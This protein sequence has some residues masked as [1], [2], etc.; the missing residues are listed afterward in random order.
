MKKGFSRNNS[1]M[2]L[3]FE[4]GTL[5][6]VE[7]HGAGDK[8][9]VRHSLRAPLSQN[10][11]TGNSELVGAEIRKHMESA[12]IRERHCVVCIP[13]SWGYFL[14]LELPEGLSNQDRENY[15]RIQAE[16][17]FPFNPE[18]LILSISYSKTG[19]EGAR[20]TAAAVPV[21]HIE[22][23]QKAL[24]SAG[25]HPRSMTLG[26]CCLA[27]LANKSRDMALVFHGEGV[28][29]AIFRDGV[30]VCIRSF[31]DAVIDDNEGVSIDDETLI[32][33]L[34]ITLG[35]LPSVIRKDVDTL[36][37]YGD[38][39]VEEIY[40]EENIK[41]FSELGLK[42]K[43]ED[44]TIYGM[45]HDSAISLYA[46][47]NAINHLS[48]KSP[49]FE[50]LKPSLGRIRKIMGRVSARRFFWL[51]IT[52]A[53]LVLILFC[54]FFIQY[55]Y[56]AH[57]ERRWKNMEEGVKEVESLKERIKKNQP[58]HD[59]AIHSLSLLKDITGAFP[60][61]GDVWVKTLEIRNLSEVQ[62]TGEA[63]N[64]R[65]WL[66]MLSKLR[67][68]SSVKD[69]KVLQV[70]EGEGLIQFSIKFVWKGISNGY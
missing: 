53:A 3:T 50:F 23:L 28:D 35:S 11:L 51:A 57:L 68:L 41:S 18:D 39:L 36:S 9:E 21:Q 48:G 43:K 46:Y 7:I 33:E 10:I 56:L 19:E 12:G 61:R 40:M 26:I 69:L 25:L 54:A 65:V 67:K 4:G 42:V 62:F 27:Q 22:V 29:A 66:E 47:V 15:I 49:C 17:A 34:R 24:K 1:I 13:L 30:P 6:A 2:G 16:R 38:P 70:K 31:S 52:S 32:R 5:S 55:Q 45:D 60:E 59:D 37:L 63:R 14:Q 20:A 64:N 44:L 8:W 58:W